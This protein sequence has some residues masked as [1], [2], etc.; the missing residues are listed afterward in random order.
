M[1]TLSTMKS[2]FEKESKRDEERIRR[3]RSCRSGRLCRQSGWNLFGKAWEGFEAF[4][5]ISAD[6]RRALSWGGLARR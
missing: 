3:S 1:A 2:T 4:A 5:V 6:G